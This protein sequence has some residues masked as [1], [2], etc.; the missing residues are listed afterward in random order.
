[1]GQF[2]EGNQADDEIPSEN[3][4]I[5]GLGFDV[6]DVTLTWNSKNNDDFLALIDIDFGDDVA[7]ADETSKRTG[8]FSAAIC[9]ESLAVL[10]D[11]ERHLDVKIAASG[12]GTPN[13]KKLSWISPDDTLEID[14]RT[15][16]MP[17]RLFEPDFEPKFTIDCPKDWIEGVVGRLG[18]E[19]PIEVTISSQQELSIGEDEQQYEMVVSQRFV[20][21]DPKKSQIECLGI[22]ASPTDDESNLDLSPQSAV[23]IVLGFEEDSDESLD[24]QIAAIDEYF[25]NSGLSKIREQVAFRSTE[26]TDFDIELSDVEKREITVGIVTSAFSR[27]KELN[28]DEQSDDG[29]ESEIEGIPAARIVI[30]R[31]AREARELLEEN[32]R[33]ESFDPMSFGHAL[34]NLASLA[35]RQG[36]LE[37]V[38]EY[39]K[40]INELPR[41]EAKTSL[42]RAYFAASRLGDKDA[43]WSLDQ[44][45][46]AENQNVFRKIQDFEGYMPRVPIDRQVLGTLIHECAGFGSLL[47]FEYIDKYTVDPDQ[48]VGDEYHNAQG[49]A[50]DNISRLPLLLIA[51]DAFKNHEIE[52]EPGSIENLLGRFASTDMGELAPG[53][54]WSVIPDI[55]SKAKD[56]ELRYELIQRFISLN[57][58]DGS[59]DGTNF[60]RLAK[61]GYE[62]LGD[63]G[64]T[65]LH[66]ELLDE[67]GLAMLETAETLK[68]LLNIQGLNQLSE[69]YAHFNVS[70]MIHGGQSV[71]RVVGVIEDEQRRWIQDTAV[72]FSSAGDVNLEMIAN[73][74]VAPLS[75]MLAGAVDQFATVG[76]FSDAQDVAERITVADDRV[77]AY[78]TA[79]AHAKTPDQVRTLMPF[80]VGIEDIHEVEIRLG[81]TEDVEDIGEEVTVYPNAPSG[82]SLADWESKDSVIDGLTSSFDSADLRT[83]YDAAV[84]SKS[85]DK[86]EM[87]KQL[88]LLSSLSLRFDPFAI[89]ESAPV[90]GMRELQLNTLFTTLTELNPVAARDVAPELIRNR[91]MGNPYFATH[92][93]LSVFYAALEHELKYGS[94]NIVR[95]T[96]LGL[97]IDRATVRAS[98]LAAFASHLETLAV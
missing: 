62:V 56:P 83:L 17:M 66:P 47:I 65:R 92:Q 10:G 61:V 45:L 67:I 22:N 78:E 4:P 54:V 55:L 27:L 9:R 48:V 93:M 71:E 64:L 2:P 72:A 16:T 59:Q 84:A 25:V 6:S 88:R 80:E 8:L 42:A 52:P 19:S 70:V 33:Q 37:S 3:L 29:I 5:G 40:I 91:L 41:D 98:R 57:K 96:I 58:H 44:L 15:V 14:C 26:S 76:K 50:V 81:S 86:D 49:S 79:W 95:S 13:A 31:S 63:E 73:A 28:A 35:S 97:G 23:S 39:C 69:S 89:D 36:D 85:E 82:D 46:E 94:L 74:S 38:Q 1:M 7:A 53:F 34:A 90:S 60:G 24:I 68:P 32:F 18:S 12:P 75:R 21:R 30:T 20:I 87:I 43:E 11:P 77:A 51:H